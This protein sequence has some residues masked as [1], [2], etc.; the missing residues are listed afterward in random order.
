MKTGNGRQ[1]FILS[2]CFLVIMI[3]SLMLVY[4]AKGEGEKYKPDVVLDFF[5]PAGEKA[6][7][8]KDRIGPLIEVLAT[9]RKDRVEERVEEGVAP[10]NLIGSC[11][12]MEGDY[13]CPMVPQVTERKSALWPLRGYGRGKSWKKE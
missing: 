6:T 1:N 5:I 3:I 8:K 2:L 11:P 13:Q 9:P 10:V 7:P 4:S 12:P